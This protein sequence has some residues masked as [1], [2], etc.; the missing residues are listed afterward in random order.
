MVLILHDE[1]LLNLQHTGLPTTKPGAVHSHNTSIRHHVVNKQL[2]SDRQTIAHL[3]YCFIA[4][5]WLRVTFTINKLHLIHQIFHIYYHIWCNGSG[6]WLLLTCLSQLKLLQSK[7]TVFLFI[8][9]LVK[10]CSFTKNYFLF[11]SLLDFKSCN[12]IQEELICL[13][14]FLGM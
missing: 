4:H 10:E 7:R 1:V 9:S 8:T 11:L 3:C 13:K 12:Y 14:I 6:V 5:R 2:C